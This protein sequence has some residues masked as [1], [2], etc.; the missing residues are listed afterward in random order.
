MTKIGFIGIGKMGFQMVKHLC[1]AGFDVSVYDVAKKNC[2]A[3]IEEGYPVKLA[4]NPRDLTHKNDFI[5]TMLPD[6]TIVEE[7][8]FAEDGIIAALDESK[9]YI[10]MTSA[11][12]SSTRCIYKAVA[13]KGAEMLDAPVSGGVRG[14]VAATLSIIVG[15]KEEVFN[16]C[17][18]IFEAM[19]K[20]IYLVGDIGA[21][22]TTKALNNLLGATTMWITSEVLC[23]GAKAG[24]NPAQ[25]LNVINTS[26]GKSVSSEVKFPKY[27]LT[28]KFDMD[29]TARLTLKDV[30]I[31]TSI[32]DDCQVPMLLG[33]TVEQL[34]S[35]ALLDDEIQDQTDIVKALEKMYAVVIKE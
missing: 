7:V 14:A 11:R 35:M 29:F 12:P 15:G 3:L 10:D 19:G 16:K 20:N 23:L 27:I 25:L 31:A 26:T 24:L 1:K 8:A 2:E 4:S 17:K 28:R 9:I 30:K 32:A 13:G 34:W 18:P 33:K 6:S 21:G 22:H 5:I